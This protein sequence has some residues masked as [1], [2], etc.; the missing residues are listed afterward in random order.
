[1][2]LGASTFGNASILM[3]NFCLWKFVC[4]LWTLLVFPISMPGWSV[5]LP[6]SF[7][8]CID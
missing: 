7:T 5:Q 3:A 6:N 2:M 1:M 8:A 4:N